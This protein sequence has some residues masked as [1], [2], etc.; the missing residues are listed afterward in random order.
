MEVMEAFISR[1]KEVNSAL[2]AVVSERFEDALQ[3]A[4]DIDKMLR[5]SKISEEYSV[6]NAPFLGV[7]FT[8]KEAFGIT[9]I[10]PSSL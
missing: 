10:L 2:N 6:E 8:A 7:P 5:S 4:K 1:I 3:Q 9:G